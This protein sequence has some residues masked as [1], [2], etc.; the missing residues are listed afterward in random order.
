MRLWIMRLLGRERVSLFLDSYKG[1]AVP[2]VMEV[3]ASEIYNRLNVRIII[4]YLGLFKF[5]AWL[6]TMILRL[7]VIVSPMM[8]DLQVQYQDPARH[9]REIW[10]M[11]R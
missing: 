2:V 7:Y 1:K 5:R 3:S 6:A 9:P 4:R 11:W 8:T 10:R